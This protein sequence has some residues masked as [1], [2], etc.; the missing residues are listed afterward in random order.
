MSTSLVGPKESRRIDPKSESRATPCRRQNSRN[1]SSS[2]LIPFSF[3]SGSLHRLSR[4]QIPSD[5]KY[6]QASHQA[7]Q[8]AGKMLVHGVDRIIRVNPSAGESPARVADPEKQ[9]PRQPDE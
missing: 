2:K 9:H 7:R 6:R 3:M 8:G 4:N 1:S 5:Q